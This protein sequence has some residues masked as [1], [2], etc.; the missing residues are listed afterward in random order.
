MWCAN[1][2]I[3]LN[4]DEGIIW[5]RAVTLCF[6]WLSFIVYEA[7]GLVF[8][9]DLSVLL[10]WLMTNELSMQ[11]FFD[12]SIETRILLFS[13]KFF[14]LAFFFKILCDFFVSLLGCNWRMYKLRYLADSWWKNYLKEKVFFSS[15]LE[16]NRLVSIAS[17]YR[18]WMI[19]RFH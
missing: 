10:A 5:N 7:L 17:G 18:F 19:N 9:T 14:H 8:F 6:C 3:L 16:S 4:C 1:C 15:L 12:P 11:S 2:I 13:S